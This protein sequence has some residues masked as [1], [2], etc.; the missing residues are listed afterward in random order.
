[1]TLP[2]NVNATTD[3]VMTMAYRVNTQK[4][5]K[6]LGTTEEDLLPYA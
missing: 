5:D 6:S 3:T 4:R 1:M 2:D